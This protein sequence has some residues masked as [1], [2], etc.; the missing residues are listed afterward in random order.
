MDDNTAAS[1]NSRGS[2]EGSHRPRA[3]RI[4]NMKKKHSSSH[5]KDKAA[6]KKTAATPPQPKEGC[7]P[8]EGGS[9]LIG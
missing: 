7:P 1:K 8:L 5:R 2:S 3:G 6:K 9:I 4:H